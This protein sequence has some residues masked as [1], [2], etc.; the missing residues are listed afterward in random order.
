MPSIFLPAGATA[1]GLPI[2]VFLEA[3]PGQDGALLQPGP[4][5]GV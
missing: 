5:A 2:G 1:T 3:L 4:D